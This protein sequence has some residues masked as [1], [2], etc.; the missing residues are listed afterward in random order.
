MHFRLF[1]TLFFK[2]FQIF[3]FQTWCICFTYL[4]YNHS[5]RDVENICCRYMYHN[6]KKTKNCKTGGK[7]FFQVWFIGEILIHSIEL[8]VSETLKLILRHKDELRKHLKSNVCIYL[9][10]AVILIVL[11]FPLLFSYSRWRTLFPPSRNHYCFSFDILVSLIVPCFITWPRMFSL[12]ICDNFISRSKGGKILINPPPP[13]PPSKTNA[14]R[15]ELK[16]N[17]KSL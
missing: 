8:F 1:Q 3:W 14:W 16:N 6:A 5:W 7:F 4:V 13:P 15:T 12:G 9:I 2:A 17:C 10:W 11:F